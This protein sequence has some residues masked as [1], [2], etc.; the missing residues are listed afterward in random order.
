VDEVT[1]GL[2]STD[3]DVRGRH[4][5]HRLRT[6]GV[7]ALDARTDDF[8]LFQDDKVAVRLVR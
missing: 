3:F 5:E 8:I 1:Q 2:V 4:R 6:F 7:D